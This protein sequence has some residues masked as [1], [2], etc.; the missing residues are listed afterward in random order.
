VESSLLLEVTSLAV[1]ARGKEIVK[2]VSFGVS[3]GKRLCLVGESGSGKTTTALA[4]MGLLQQKR[5]FQVRGSVNFEGKELLALSRKGWQNIHGKELSMIFQDPQASLNPIF[6]IGDQV[7]EMVEIHEDLSE[8]DAVAKTLDALKS[9]GLDAIDPFETYPHQLSGGMKQRVMIAMSLILSPKL[10]IAD[11]PTS[12]LDLTVQKDILAL[13]KKFQ[14]AL[15]L[16]THDFG[17][18]AEMADDVAV[19]YKGEIVEYGSCVDVLHN[20]THAY[21]KALLAARPT[22]ENRKKILPVV[23]GI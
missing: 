13:V 21:T 17:V 19:M 23:S 2:G 5:S 9:V 20:P 7:L 22:K 1:S 10:L 6:T 18:V 3:F 16:I 4:I 11:E 8:D 12:A 15:L 14:G